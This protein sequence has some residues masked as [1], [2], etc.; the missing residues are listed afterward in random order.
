MTT[1]QINNIMTKDKDAQMLSEAYKTIREEFDPETYNVAAHAIAML[2][3][4][5][6]AK[7]KDLIDKKLAETQQTDD[8]TA[9]IG[10]QLPQQIGP[11]GTPTDTTGTGHGISSTLRRDAANLKGKRF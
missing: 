7:L 10:K 1:W 5:A 3:G 9:K 11:D 4:V 8:S 2:G 6:L